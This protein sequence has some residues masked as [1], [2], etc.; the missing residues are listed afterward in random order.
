MLREKVKIV[1]IY[2]SNH[3]RFVKQKP[4]W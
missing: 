3:L 1:L 4:N 2:L